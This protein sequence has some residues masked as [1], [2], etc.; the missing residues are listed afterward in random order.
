MKN[1]ITLSVSVLLS[2][3]TGC[4]LFV[5]RHQSVSIQ[6]SEPAHAKVWIDGA[7]QGEAP[8]VVSLPRNQTYCI[9]VKQDG[10]QP[11]QRI[12]QYGLNTTGALD[13]V[14]TFTFIIPVLGLVSPGAQSLDDTA[15][16]FK[17]IPEE[18]QQ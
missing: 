6:V 11:S 12:L 18:K 16:V 10:Y 1:L 13:L 2:L 17:L 7:Y 3:T 14:G 4:S 8:V 9:I 5:G 15:L